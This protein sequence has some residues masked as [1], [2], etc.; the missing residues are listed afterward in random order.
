MAKKKNARQE[1]LEKLQEEYARRYPV[2]DIEAKYKIFMHQDINKRNELRQKIKNNNGYCISRDEHIPKNHCMCEQFKNRDSEGWC[3][4]HL[5]YKELR[6]EKQAAAFKSSKLSFDD[7]KELALE[8]QM[9][10]EAKAEAK[11]IEQLEGLNGCSED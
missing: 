1:Y 11:K 5:Y 6:T 3:K 4:C 7:K 9:L 10:A 8:K 2:S